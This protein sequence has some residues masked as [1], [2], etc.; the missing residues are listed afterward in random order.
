MCAIVK[1]ENGV[2]RIYL[3]MM[4]SYIAGSLP[5]FFVV[6]LYCVTIETKISS[7]LDFFSL[8]T[9]RMKRETLIV[10]WPTKDQK[11]VLSKA[12]SQSKTFRTLLQYTLYFTA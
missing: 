7:R 8:F 2:K 12:R 1:F 6:Q 10:K 3:R 4:R 5:T 11:K 9:N